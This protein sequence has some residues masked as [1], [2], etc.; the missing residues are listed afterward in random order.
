MTARKIIG[1]ILV[2]LP[3]LGFLLAGLA[4]L[5]GAQSEMFVGW[6]YPAWFA[7][8][9]GVL[10]VGGAI[11]LLVPKT[12]RTAAAGLSVIMAGAVATHVMNAE[13][14]QLVRPLAFAALMWA[15]WWLRSGGDDG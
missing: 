10:E 3:A 1:W 8:V 4:K 7:Y 9:I 2:V 13:A 15:G 6:G 11:G 12:T 14:A 5:M